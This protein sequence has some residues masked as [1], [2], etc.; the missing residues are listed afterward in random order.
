MACLA[1]LAT[2]G[3][4]TRAT[5]HAAAALSDWQEDVGYN[6]LV[7]ALGDATPDGTG[8]SFSQVEAAAVPQGESLNYNLHP[9]MPYPAF[10][11]GE[12]QVEWSAGE[13][14]FN[15]V[16]N[17]PDAMA[18]GEPVYLG[19]ATGTVGFVIYGNS[20]GLATGLTTVN[21][22]EANDWL[23]NILK[24]NGT[25][26]PVAQ[27]YRVQN[28]SW[29]GTL[30]SSGVPNHDDP[31]NITAL[32]RYDYI[33]DTAN[34]GEGMTALVGVN[35]NTNPLPYLM[36]QGYNS[37]AVGRSD[38]V[39]SSG[40]TGTGDANLP[41]YYYGEGRSKPDLVAPGTST[42]M[43]TGMA[44]SAALILHETLAATP[45]RNAETVKSIML[46]GAQKY[47]E[48][49]APQDRTWPLWQPLGWSNATGVL[50]MTQPLDDT[51]GAGEVDVW[52]NYLIASG[53]Q[54]AG[55]FTEPTTVATNNGWDYRD[56]KSQQAAGPV[57]Y[58]LDVPEG[59]TVQELSIVLSWHVKVT[60]T[61][62]GTPFSPSHSLQDLNLKLYDS[63]SG[64]LDTLVAE[65]VSSVDNVEQLFF[66]NIDNPA[67]GA[68]AA[69][70]NL[71]PGTY[72]IE[73]TGAAGW[74]YGLAWR[75][76]TLFDTPSADFDDNGLV[77]GRDYLLWQRGQGALQGAV[78]GDGDADGDGDVDE[79]DLAILQST[80][81]TSPGVV[82]VAAAALLTAVPEPGTLI[83]AVL[84]TGVGLAICRR[85]RTL[86]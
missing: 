81:G 14:T 20:S 65:S 31:K 84:S 34:G 18:D 36:S 7:A 12:L 52:N 21:N 41:N 25:Q 9:Y 22:Y 44:S 1:V 42:S 28:H 6:K 16:R 76:S 69:A 53:G 58:T 39:H 77:D 27:N 63:T 73:V 46:A 32:Q 15:D 75:M 51:Y 59:T 35:N 55:S 60:D 17:L 47:Q 54:T 40:L 56:L 78:H 26:T 38:G 67:D 49:L 30:A 80:F 62:A 8:G 83:L 79:A 48:H 37:I 19:H 68:F 43:A 71:D 86:N 2:V 13:I 64:F 74:D 24:Y 82:P 61:N 45:G 4:L 3:A 23:T 57:Y 85:R 70:N 29:A 5:S 50:Q 10:T 66:S 72:T 33:I 11:N